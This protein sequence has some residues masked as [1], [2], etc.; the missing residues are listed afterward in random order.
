MYQNDI[1]VIKVSDE[2]PNLLMDHGC[3]T[4]FLIGQFRPINLPVPFSLSGYDENKVQ[5]KDSSTIRTLDPQDLKVQ[6]ANK[7]RTS[8][9]G[10]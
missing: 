10:S 3:G 5:H 9:S 8:V 2:T 6:F 4:Q 7:K 1:I